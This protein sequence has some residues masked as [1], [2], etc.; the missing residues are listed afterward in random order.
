MSETINAIPVEKTERQKFVDALLEF[1]AFF[2]AHPEVELPQSMMTVYLFPEV[3]KMAPYAKAFG[4]C[5]KSGDENFFN[6]TKT[7][8]SA[9]E[10]QAAWYRNQ[11]CER[12]VVGQKAVERAVMQEVGKETVMQDIVEWKCPKILEPIAPA[13]LLEGANEIPF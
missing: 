1:A 5:R 8:G 6:L 7:F 9:L 2:E 11:V 13:E 12:V 10:L 3:S 4:K